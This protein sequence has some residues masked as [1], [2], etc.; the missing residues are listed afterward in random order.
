LYINENE[1]LGLTL[2]LGSKK[3]KTV[4]QYKET[5]QEEVL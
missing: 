2:K 3:L 5:K 1:H 4:I